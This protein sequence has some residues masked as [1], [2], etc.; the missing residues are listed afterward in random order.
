MSSATVVVS[1]IICLAASSAMAAG[2]TGS[3]ILTTGKSYEYY[4]EQSYVAINP[5]TGDYRVV[6]VVTDLFQGHTHFS[7]STSKTHR[8]DIMLILS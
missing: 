8:W 3:L 5:N 1:I 7:L 6:S 2:F 4:K